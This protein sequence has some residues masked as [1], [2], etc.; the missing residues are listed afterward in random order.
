[1]T[2]DD[3]PS[4]VTM[5]RGEWQALAEVLERA[6]DVVLEQSESPRKCQC[7]SNNAAGGWASKYAGVSPA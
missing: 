1:M 6:L 7:A 5:P 4:T 3:E 2:Q